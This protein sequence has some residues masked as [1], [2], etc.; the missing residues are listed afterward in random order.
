MLFHP[1]RRTQTLTRLRIVLSAL[2]LLLAGSI[3][4]ADLIHLE[5]GGIVRGDI[6]SMTDEE[7]TVKTPAGLQ[8]FL[9]QNIAR[10][11][12]GVSVEGQFKERLKALKPTDADG[13]YQLGLE[14]RK[15]R[16]DK[17]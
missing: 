9:R 3:A 2:A 14:M 15:L 17:E 1:R 5:G 12:R 16:Q 6:V 11:E 4:R 10:F 7:V 8:K 13:H